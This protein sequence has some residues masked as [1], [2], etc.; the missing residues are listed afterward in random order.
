MQR[1][2][3]WKW[4]SAAHVVCLGVLLVSKEGNRVRVTWPVA[5]KGTGA[6]TFS[7][8]EAQPLIESMALAPEDGE[9]R[10]IA[11]GLD[12]VTLLTVGS[13]NLNDTA[14]WMAFFDNPPKREHETHAV[15]LGER[16]L[17]VTEKGAS[18]TV[19]VAR[20]SAAGFHGVVRFT[21]YRN[22]ALVQAETVLETE[23]DGRAIVYDTGLAAADPQW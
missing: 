23:E 19:T 1:P 22:S 11:R 4:M 5:G 20:A 18:S 10:V 3:K 14:G 6:V 2:G 9:P 21:F 13:R 7:L 12:P 16:F 15:K 17:Q 8:D